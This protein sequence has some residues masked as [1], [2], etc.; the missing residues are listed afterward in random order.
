MNG[1]LWTAVEEMFLRKQYSTVAI[2]ELAKQFKRSEQ[3]VA[4]RASLLG[5]RKDKRAENPHFAAHRFPKGHVPQNKGIRRPGF[6]AGRMAETQFK[7]GRK[8][9]N[10]MP[11]GSTLTNADGYLVRKVADTGYPPRDWKSVHTLLWEEKNG[12][13]P[14]GHC[15]AFKDG[16]KANVTLENVELITRVERMRRNTIHNLPNDLKATIQIAAVLKRT[17]TRRE[18]QNAEKHDERSSQPS[19]RDA[20]GA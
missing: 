10:W 7:K 3:S 17:I 19:L 14:A 18:K 20:R 4:V 12:P 6:A 9:H 8:P 13:V 16:N 5:L 11:L 1:R 15:L 2:G